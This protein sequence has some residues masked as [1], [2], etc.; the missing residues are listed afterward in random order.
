MSMKN[1]K[2][3]TA[4]D[5]MVGKTSLLTSFTSNKYNP[6]YNPTI[7]NSTTTG[8]EVDRTPYTLS[9]WDSSG[10][11]EYSLLRRLSYHDTDLFLICFAINNRTSFDNIKTKWF[12]EL[13]SECP[14]GKLLLVGTKGDLRLSS[15]YNEENDEK[16]EFVSKEEAEELRKD[17][18][19]VA[20]VECSSITQFN[21]RLIFETAVRAVVDLPPK[22]KK[23]HHSCFIL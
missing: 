21:L 11:E 16:K 4:G 18:E 22:S 3:V 10:Q 20:Y 8:I 13:N 15:S 7:F 23:K 2:I 14:T 5:G 19:G 12:Q 1:I 6:D 9:L 17:I